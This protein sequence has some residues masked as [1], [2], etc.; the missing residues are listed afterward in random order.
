M[1]FHPVIPRDLTEKRQ[2]ARH[3]HPIYSPYLSR[4]SPKVERYSYISRDLVQDRPTRTI[5]DH[6]LYST[7]PWYMP[8]SQST[9][10][11]KSLESPLSQ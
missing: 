2:T 7:C 5:H 9:H 1:T 4:K 11:D 3:P 10:T 6:A 8:P